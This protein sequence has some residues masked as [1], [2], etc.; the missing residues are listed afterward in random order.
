MNTRILALIALGLAGCGDKARCSA[1]SDPDLEDACRES[2]RA[3]DLLGP[4]GV[5]L[6]QDCVDSAAAVCE[7]EDTDAVDEG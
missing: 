4:V 3:C 7:A 5:L 1:C 6:H 2:M